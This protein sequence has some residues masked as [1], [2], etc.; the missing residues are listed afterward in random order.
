[1]KLSLGDYNEPLGLPR[2]SVRAL[3]TLVTVLP[4]PVVMVLAALGRELPGASMAWYSAM[5]LLV[6]RDYFGSRREEGQGV[7]KDEGPGDYAVG[8][9]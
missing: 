3:V 7:A 1:M 9:D 4:V 2:G 5:V 6:L 8:G